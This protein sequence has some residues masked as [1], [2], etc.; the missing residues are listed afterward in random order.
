MAWP[1]ERAGDL[2]CLAAEREA[3]TTIQNHFGA[4]WILP[5][6]G[7]KFPPSSTATAA[8]AAVDAHG[9]V[10]AGLLL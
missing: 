4:L 5:A 10:A 7:R 8:G 9:G 1:L 3:A 6:K 2:L